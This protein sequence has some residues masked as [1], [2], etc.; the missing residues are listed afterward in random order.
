MPYY[1]PGCQIILCSTYQNVEKYTKL[2][3]NIPTA[4]N[5]YQMAVIHID[6]ISKYVICQHLLLQDPP[7]ITLIWIFGLKIP[8][9]SGNPGCINEV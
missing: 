9:S 3:Q 4:H 2:H 6:Q 5:V 7:K 8:I 1:G